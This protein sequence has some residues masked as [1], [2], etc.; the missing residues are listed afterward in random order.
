ME[1]ILGIVIGI[2]IWQFVIFVLQRCEME[3][4]WWS[5]PIPYLFLLIFEGILYI[6][7]FFKDFPLYWMIIKWGYNPFKVSV[8]KLQSLTDEQKSQMIEKACP[9]TKIALK[10]IFKL[11]RMS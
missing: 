8:V 10:R 7:Y 1:M 9:R 11:N 2:V 6:V 3:D 4:G 5:V